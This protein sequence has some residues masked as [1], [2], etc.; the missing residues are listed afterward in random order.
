MKVPLVEN[1]TPTWCAAA[2]SRISKKSGRSIGSPP[3]MLT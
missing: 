2:Y 3:P 1:F